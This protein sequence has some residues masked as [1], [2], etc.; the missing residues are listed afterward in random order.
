M[1]PRAAL[2]LVAALAVATAAHQA[3][4]QSI[5]DFVGGVID[6]F[7]SQA[8]ERGLF[9]GSSRRC[10]N[11]RPQAPRNLEARARNPTTVRL[12]WRAKDN[13]CVDYYEITYSAEGT[14]V[15]RTFSPRKVTDYTVDISDLEP[16]TKYVF[17]VRAV[18]D[19]NGAS[20][21]AQARATTPPSGNRCNGAP[22]P[23]INVQTRSDSPT[24]ITVT[25]LTQVNDP[26]I[27][28]FEV[29]YTLESASFAPR[30][31]A[32]LYVT[33]K[34]VT[35]TNLQP[36]STYNIVVASV[37]K[38][39]QRSSVTTRGK[40]QPNCSSPPR[41]PANTFGRQTGP[42]SVQL[43]WQLPEKACVP[44]STQVTYKDNLTG[45]TG[46]VTQIG[47]SDQS[48]TWGN[49]QPG[50]DYTFSVRFV[51]RDGSKSTSSTARVNLP[52]NSQGGTVV[53]GGR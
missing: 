25:W 34:T 42:K 32:P 51:G 28:R 53:V 13:S 6:G 2:V 45:S 24:T 17:N 3:Q 36:D 27:E 14:P 39:G 1:A 52:N 30:S 20:S 33:E 37:S 9:P 46:P 11:K 15:P 5:G 26:C 29:T 31:L 50:R 12:T 35:L 48:F 40:T 49:L 22:T 38:S 23:P 47:G 41:A 7:L 21:S 8:E 18:N 4:A 16:N 10:A 43:T 19:K 44:A